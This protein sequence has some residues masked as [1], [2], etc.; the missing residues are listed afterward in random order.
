[1]K[2]QTNILLS[3]LLVCAVASL[4]LALDKT[5]YDPNLRETRKISVT[6][7]I[8]IVTHPPG[9]L[10]NTSNTLTKVPPANSTPPPDNVEW[11][12]HDQ[13]HN[14]VISGFQALRQARAP[15][16]GLEPATEGSLQISGRTRKPLCYRRPQKKKK[17][18]K[19]KK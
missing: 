19:K 10:S 4:G 11:L 3:L 6:N 5:T 7:W 14:K 17:K 9:E 2:V 12:W 13:V 18:K 1:M 15:V 8:R 16:A